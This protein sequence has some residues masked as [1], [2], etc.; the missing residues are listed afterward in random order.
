MKLT[1]L[2][3]WFYPHAK[4]VGE[5][6]RPDKPEWEGRIPILVEDAWNKQQH[7]IDILNYRITYL[8]TTLEL[9][10]KLTKIMEKHNETH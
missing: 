10:T 3:E 2:E 8:E 9:V 7:K 5:H 4:R 6:L 1:E